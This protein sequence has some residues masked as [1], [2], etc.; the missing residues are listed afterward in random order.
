[1]DEPETSGSQPDQTQEDETT[2]TPETDLQEVKWLRQIVPRKTGNRKDVYYFDVT[3]DSSR[4]RSVNEI[5]S[6]CRKNDIHFDNT[7]FSFSP[8]DTFQGIINE[9]DQSTNQTDLNDEESDNSLVSLS[10]L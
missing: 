10:N 8:R 2:V 7:L 4:L 9:D 3:N 5:E 1:M 6:Y